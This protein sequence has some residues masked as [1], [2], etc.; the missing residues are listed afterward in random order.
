MNRFYPL[1]ANATNIP[2]FFIDSYAA[3]DQL[4]EDAC[5][6]IR[7][8]TSLLEAFTSITFKGTNDS[9]FYRLIL[10]AYLLLQDGV[11]TLEQISFKGD[12]LHA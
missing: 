10:P 7:A 9:D 12:G 5:F 2:T 11:D 1:K 6:R 8:A 3:R 4:F